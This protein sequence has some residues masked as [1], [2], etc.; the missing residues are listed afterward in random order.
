MNWKTSW[1]QKKLGPTLNEHAMGQPFPAVSRWSCR[2]ATSYA[3]D[4]DPWNLYG[5]GGKSHQIWSNMSLHWHLQRL[6]VCFNT[7][8]W[9]KHHNRC[10]PVRRKTVSQT[11]QEW[12]NLWI[13]SF[14]RPPEKHFHVPCTRG[15]STASIWTMASLPSALDPKMWIQPLALEDLSLGWNHLYLCIYIYHHYNVYQIQGLVI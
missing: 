1:P 5:F 9:V 8:V 10:L 15:T 14:K 4:S 13:W 12:F 6:H 3:M 7:H 2:F 11:T